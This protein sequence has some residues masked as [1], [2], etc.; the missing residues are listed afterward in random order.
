MAYALTDMSVHTVDSLK[1]FLGS[2]GEQEHV[3]SNDLSL[4]QVEHLKNG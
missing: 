4:Q 3:S 2:V 1:P